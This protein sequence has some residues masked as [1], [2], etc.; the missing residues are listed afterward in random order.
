[1]SPM[2]S[3][4]SYWERRALETEEVIYEETEA[5]RERMKVIYDKARMEF[6]RTA[7]AWITRMAEANGISYHEAMQRLKTGELEG[8]RMDLDEF[9]EACENLPF[10]QGTP[11][12]EALEKMIET[13]SARAHVTR[14]EELM[15][16]AQ[17]VATE[18]FAKVGEEGKEQLEYAYTEGYYRTGKDIQDGIGYHSSLAEVDKLQLEAIL[19]ES[20]KGSNYSEKI[21]KNRDALADNLVE[22]VTQSVIT[23]EPATKMAEE[24]KEKFLASLAASLRLLRTE[25]SHIA[26]EGAQKA[27][28]EI[29]LEKYKILSTLDSVTCKRCG[30][31]DGVSIEVKE[32][33]PGV[34]SPPFHP[35]C[36]CTTV[37]DVDDLDLDLDDEGNPIE[38][39][40]VYRDEN[41]KS[42]IGPEMSYDE[43]KKKYVGGDKSAK[44]D[45]LLKAKAEAA[46]YIE[47]A[48]ND[49][50][51]KDDGKDVEN[52]KAPDG[53]K[54]KAPFGGKGISNTPTA[55]FYS[56][57][58]GL[59]PELKAGK[60]KPSERPYS[61]P[62]TL[63]SAVVTLL[64]NGIR[65]FDIFRRVDPLVIK[66]FAG[67]INHMVERVPELAELHKK[68]P[69][70]KLIPV[71]TEKMWE[72]LGKKDD[73]NVPRA[74]YY[75]DDFGV[76]QG[77][78]INT[79]F[80]SPRNIGALF[81][82][83]A[84]E[85]LNGKATKGFV[86]EGILIHEYGHYLSNILFG[87]VYSKVK[88][89]LDKI[90]LP[91]HLSERA[92]KSIY[93]KFAEVV[94]ACYGHDNREPYAV[95]FRSAVEAAI[96]EKAKEL[97][98][99]RKKP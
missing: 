89:F 30:A 58:G 24:I 55:H 46:K 43:W 93:E 41:G 19:E 78:L 42:V 64:K 33:K 37:P 79:D 16:N 56:D 81:K 3:D 77:I 12:G 31:L 29:G 62:K 82:K 76:T 85:V 90:G 74:A 75:V 11:E 69:I 66:D 36:R 53:K 1:M 35:N 57:K 68:F 49:K 70:R 84:S 39:E 59:T 65:Y 83:V 92:N 6:E 52:Y 54:P 88:A 8:L 51:P 28:E 15:Y 14:I 22:I 13:A 71:N 67:F 63:I 80:F 98:N 44:V 26:Q 27:Y 48:K 38:E 87:D 94:A 86:P 21:W 60:I 34:N 45:E 5:M 9:R 32:R 7:V 25:S 40:R 95:K 20:W 96:K 23:G 72:L 17:K 61:V 50:A 73:D 4:L 91:E 97:Q 18:L 99:A 47:N 10:L 2:K